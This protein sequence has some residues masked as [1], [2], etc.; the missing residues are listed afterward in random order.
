MVN[1]ANGTIKDIIY[2]K[3]Y[4]KNDLPDAIFIEFD[5]YTSPKFFSENDFRYRWI[6]IDALDIYNPNH[7][8]NRIQYSI[9]LS[10]AL[11]IH[12]SQGQTIDKAVIDLGKTE[13][14]LGL[15][16][17]ALYRL[18]NFG[19]FLILPSTLTSI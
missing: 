12:K 3:N 13:R 6:P 2:G 17:V 5:Y 9:R 19:E 16:Y 4:Q 10:Y 14:S 11:T 15:T 18:K 1:G 7:G 8:T